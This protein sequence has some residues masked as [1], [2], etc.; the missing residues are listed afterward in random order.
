MRDPTANLRVPSANLRVP[1]A[2]L[3]V[4]VANLK[5]SV[6]NHKECAFWAAAPIGDKVLQ[7]GEK[8]RPSFRTSVHPSICYTRGLRAVGG[9]RGLAGGV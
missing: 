3:W 4:T 5:V 8:F 7:N 9:V 1:R 2:H 6:L